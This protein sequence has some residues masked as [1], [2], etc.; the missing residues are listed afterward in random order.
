MGGWVETV[1][2][3]YQAISSIW[4]FDMAEPNTEIRRIL[5]E[6]YG[7]E[8]FIHDAEAAVVHRDD[9]GILYRLDLAGHE[10][11]V[12]VKVVTSSPEVDGSF[13]DYFGVPPWMQ[14]ARE[15]VAWTFSMNEQG[16]KPDQES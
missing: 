15:A 5:V 11:W 8:R 16:Y 6:R 7:E 13:R 3:Q 1:P 9:F 4:V 10:P 14:T 12:S 2:V